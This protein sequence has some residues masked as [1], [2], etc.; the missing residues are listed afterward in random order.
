MS[1]IFDIEEEQGNINLPHF[2]TTKRTIKIKMPLQLPS[3]DIM[4]STT[5]FI[6]V[7]I[8]YYNHFNK[9]IRLLIIKLV[10]KFI[11]MHF[12]ALTILN[13]IY[14]YYHSNR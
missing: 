13:L 8:T 3:T 9:A 12:Y 4:V 5:I 6:T 2:L 11:F 14:N 7:T 10:G 1:K